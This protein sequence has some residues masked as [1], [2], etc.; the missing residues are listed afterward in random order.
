MKTILNLALLLLLILSC[1]KKE[2][3]TVSEANGVKIYLNNGS[4]SNPN[5][6]IKTKELFRIKGASDSTNSDPDNFFC[7]V[8]TLA[9]DDEGCIYVLSREAPY[10]KKF[11]KN[12]KFI[13]SFLGSGTGPSETTCKPDGMWFQNNTILV[14]DYH[15]KQMV[16]YTK[17]GEYI[18]N[19]STKDSQM[20]VY[21]QPVGDNKFVSYRCDWPIIDDVQYLDYTLSLFSTDYKLEADLI[22]QSYKANELGGRETI[23]AF[24]VTDKSIYLSKIDISNYVIDILDF[25]GKKTAKIVKPFRKI[26]FNEEELKYN[27]GEEIPKFAEQYKYP[28]K[29][30]YHAKDNRIWALVDV[31]RNKENF[32]DYFVDVFNEGVFEN[33]VKLN[34]SANY[35]IPFFQPMYV[36]KDRIYFVNNDT[37]EILVYEYEYTG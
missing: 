7:Q 36:T 23:H 17:S 31:E 4:P 26:L 15:K 3:Y 22:K 13:I 5:F 10:V 18:D 27:Y 24:T 11:D 32:N 2:T 37:S 21:T 19:Q 12:G 30:L 29:Q 1:S 6:S 9:F 14:L 16:R 28:V 8:F 34:I 25:N 33:R 35:F 20:P